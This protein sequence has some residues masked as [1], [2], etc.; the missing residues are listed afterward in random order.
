MNKLFAFLCANTIIFATC[1]DDSDGGPSRGLNFESW[2]R[3]AQEADN[4][5]DDLETNPEEEKESDEKDQKKGN[6]DE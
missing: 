6:S 3:F 2:S 1:P 5:D 4:N